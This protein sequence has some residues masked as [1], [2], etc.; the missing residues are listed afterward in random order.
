LLTISGFIA[1]VVITFAAAAISSSEL[2]LPGLSQRLDDV[3]DCT[4]NN[5]GHPNAPEVLRCG[6]R[7]PRGHTSG[8]CDL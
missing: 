7:Y 1:T 2:D 6:S 8:N 3:E 5:A 4:T